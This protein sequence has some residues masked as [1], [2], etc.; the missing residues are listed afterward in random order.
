M[1]RV[2]SVRDLTDFVGVPGDPDDYSDQVRSLWDSGASRSEW[3]FI[4]EEDGAPIGR[5]G[6]GVSPTVSDPVWLGSLPSD[7]LFVFGLHL[8]WEDSA[9]STGSLLIRDALTGIASQI[10]ETLELRVNNSIH[11]HARERVRLA[12]ALGMDLFQEKIG[13]TWEDNG[14]P[15][16]PGDRLTFRS[17]DQ[18][19]IDAY[20]AVMAPCGDGTLDRNDRYYWHGCGPDNWA[21]QMTEYLGPEDAPMW[22]TGFHE[23]V[24]VGY[25]AVSAVDDWGSTI[26][27]VGVLPEHRGHGYIQDLLMAGMASARRRGIVT[28][29][30]DVDVLNAPM[31]H[32]MIRAGQAE[33]P[34]RWHLW[35][36]R[37]KVANL[38]G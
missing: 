28:M 17:I 10:P 5:I 35:V 23:D 13:F 7:E 14:E 1:L 15:I 25:V 37:A 2:R 30:S 34:N 16:L 9:V 24:P 11:P 36:H 31:R 22:L 12:G 18:S 20:R 32:A 29:L 6:L 33:N 21:A 38:V 4:L 27:H 19:G 3:C 8:P 26:V